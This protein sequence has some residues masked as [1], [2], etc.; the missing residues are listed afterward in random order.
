MAGVVSVVSLLRAG[1]FRK[2]HGGGG[3]AG[4]AGA[5][6]AAWIG[7]INSLSD[8]WMNIIKHPKT[9]KNIQKHPKTSKQMKK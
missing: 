7:Q 1:Q 6:A 4:E 5:Q 2:K 3:E 9:S 8:S